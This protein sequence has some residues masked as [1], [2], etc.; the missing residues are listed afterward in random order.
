MARMALSAGIRPFSRI[1][2]ISAVDLPN[3]SARMR[4]ADKPASVNC[5]TS[6]PDSFPLAWIC[7]SAR[8]MRSIE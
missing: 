4:S 3:A 6:S 7:P 2:T 1:A 8:L 5:R